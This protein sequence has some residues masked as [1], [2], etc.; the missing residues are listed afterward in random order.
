M[1]PSCPAT[2]PTMEYE[3]LPTH[4]AAGV[5]R[6]TAN[7]L[8]RVTLFFCLSVNCYYEVKSESN[9]NDTEPRN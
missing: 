6:N 7:L 1:T 8:L 3:V 4:S 2:S 5:I 9:S